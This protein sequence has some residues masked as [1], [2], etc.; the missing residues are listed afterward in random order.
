MTEALCR[1]ASGFDF[2]AG[3]VTYSS[4]IFVYATS[5]M[6]ML[7]DLVVAVQTFPTETPLTVSYFLL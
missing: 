7:W 1:P 4:G 6:W 5:Y 2:H 3:V